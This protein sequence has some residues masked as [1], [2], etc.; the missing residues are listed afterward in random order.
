MHSLSD[1]ISTSNGLK[2]TDK[3]RFFVGD[4]PAQQ[5]ERGTQQGGKF[6]CGGCGVGATL[7]IFYNNL[8]AAYTNYNILPLQKSMVG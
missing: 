3:L 8:G 5:F 7:H 2:I 1:E 6:K 4:H